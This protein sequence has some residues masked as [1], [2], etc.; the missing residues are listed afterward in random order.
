MVDVDPKLQRTRRRSP[1]LHSASLYFLSPVK[2]RAPLVYGR[3]FCGRH[4]STSEEPN[5]NLPIEEWC[6]SN[7]KVVFAYW[8]RLID[9][10]FG[11]QTWSFPIKT[12][13]TWVLGMPICVVYVF[14]NMLS[15]NGLTERQRSKLGKALL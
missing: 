7:E 10:C 2:Y 12:K 14:R 8:T 1:D 6:S 4:G 9:P 3:R 5:P 11:A 13:V 15:Q